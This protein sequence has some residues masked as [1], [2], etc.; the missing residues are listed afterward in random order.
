MLLHCADKQLTSFLAGWALLMA[1]V[2]FWKDYRTLARYKY[3]VAA[4]AVLLLLVTTI[5][6]STANGQTIALNLGFVKFQP[7]DL[8][9]LLLVIFMAAYLIEKRELLSFAA[10]RFGILTLMDLRYMGP[11][12]ALWVITL[13]IVFKHQD[14][15]AMLLLFGA[16]LGMLYL[17]TDRK[18][19]V[20]IGLV[21][22]VAGAAGAYAIS[23][24]VHDRVNLWLDQP[25]ARQPSS[26]PAD[27]HSAPR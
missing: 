26:R 11:L 18:S 12:V 17:G 10:G 7:H 3:V 25:A 22:F 21:M 19:Y 8:V 1:L 23:S 5:F 27:A 16:L 20:V 14:L 9:K 24:R 15:G 2:L 6:G 4:L 13:A